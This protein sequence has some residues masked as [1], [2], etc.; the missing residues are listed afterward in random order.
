VVSVVQWSPVR[1]TSYVPRTRWLPS[2]QKKPRA[3]GLYDTS[4]FFVCW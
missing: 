2:A 3:S 4:R 1:G